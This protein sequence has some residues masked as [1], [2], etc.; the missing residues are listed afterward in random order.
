MESR[1]KENA[2]NASSG[3]THLELL[4]FS[5]GED[6]KTG[7]DELFGVNV[8]K[9][10]EI[11]PIPEITHAPDMPDGVVGLV[12]IRKEIIPVLDLQKVC[13]IDTNTKPQI[14][15]ITEYSN[16]VHGFLVHKVESIHRLSWKEMREPPPLLTK[17][18]GGLVTAVSELKDNRLMMLLDVE[19]VLTELT[20]EDADVGFHLVEKISVKSD[21]KIFFVDDSSAARKQIARTLE[22][23]G[24]EYLFSENGK[25][26]WQQLDRLAQDTENKGLK[27]SDN[28]S[29]ILTD[30]EMPELDGYELTKKIKADPRFA[31]IPVL[32]HSSLTSK[33]NTALGLSTGADDYIGK[34]EPQEL[35]KVITKHV[36]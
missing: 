4:L 11:I 20:D 6:K 24:L 26:A 16:H 23:M 7:R 25:I 2:V 33:S 17:K 12:S 1:E 19:K 10:R 18:L 28:I 29:A 13:N 36:K 32:L 35:A 22:K 31:N 5:L 14:M 21:K 9:V 3:T 34:F 15:I 30:I 8:F 27:L